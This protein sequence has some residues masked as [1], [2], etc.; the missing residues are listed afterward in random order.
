[1]RTPR[2]TQKGQIGTPW[3]HSWTMKRKNYIEESNALDLSIN[4]LE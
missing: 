1:M 4:I 2:V 3:E